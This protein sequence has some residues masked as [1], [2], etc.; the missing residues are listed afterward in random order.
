MI[1]VIFILLIGVLLGWFW[2]DYSH[3][4]AKKP[5]AQKIKIVSKEPKKPALNKVEKTNLAQNIIQ[6]LALK[7]IKYAHILLAELI[8]KRPYAAQTLML[9]SDVYLQEGKYLQALGALESVYAQVQ[10]EYPNEQIE[11]NML[12]IA[13]LYLAQLGDDNA[14][15]KLKFSQRMA[16]LL[17][18]YSHFR[19]ALVN[20]LI[21]L[22]RYDEAAYQLDYLAHNQ[23]W[24]KQFN[25]AKK[26]LDYALIFQ[27][28][29]VQIPL[30]YD[31]G[32]WQ[33]EAIIGNKTAI[34]LLD[35][36]ANITTLGSHI[37]DGQVVK[38]TAT[39]VLNTANGRTLGQKVNIQNFSIGTISKNN[40]PVA[41]LPQSKLPPHI[42]GLLG[43]NWFTNFDF[44][45]DKK[46][47][48]LHI[49]PTN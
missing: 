45:I 43:T 20:L 47:S 26:N 39:I 9:S 8:K 22:E 21:A 5:I 31:R 14:L 41:V 44:V 23:A 2:Q 49:T 27:S 19:F 32:S 13:R 10:D 25:T 29:E 18:E 46:Q 4:Q 30:I 16:D 33:L 17:P 15:Q 24:T 3:Q 35:T 42:D 28:G 11:Q 12:S 34:L 6:A 7:E 38:N 37:I 40:F 36:G 48:I 1:K